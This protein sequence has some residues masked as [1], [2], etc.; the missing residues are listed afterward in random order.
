LDA[1]CSRE[2]TLEWAE[3]GDQLTFTWQGTTPDAQ[4]AGALRMVMPN[5]H[6][7]VDTAWLLEGDTLT[8]KDAQV[9]SAMDVEV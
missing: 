6:T 8:F 9:Q 7:T 3:D 2:I 4:K 1:P 5:C